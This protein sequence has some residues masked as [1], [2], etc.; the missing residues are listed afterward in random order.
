MS[1]KYDKIVNE[2]NEYKQK[3][4]DLKKKSCSKKIK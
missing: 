1:E 4:E 2:L 3:Y